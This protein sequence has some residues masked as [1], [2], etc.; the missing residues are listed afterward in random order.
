MSSQI[1]LDSVQEHQRVLSRAERGDAEEPAAGGD[2]G[3]IS[4]NLGIVP[5]DALDEVPRLERDRVDVGQPLGPDRDCPAQRPSRA[6][7]GSGRRP[8]RM[9]ISRRPEGCGVSP[10]LGQVD[11]PAWRR[12]QGRPRPQV[13]VDLGP[14]LQG[15]GEEEHPPTRSPQMPVSNGLA[16]LPNTQPNQRFCQLTSEPPKACESGGSLRPGWA[17]AGADAASAIAS[18]AIVSSERLIGILPCHLVSLLSCCGSPS[19]RGTHPAPSSRS[20]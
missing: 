11:G 8:R 14:R 18:A 10:G 7:A 2:L 19:T 15:G 4:R 9:R 5:I 16:L 6:A 1:A 20:P 13:T 17:A 3:M 12:E